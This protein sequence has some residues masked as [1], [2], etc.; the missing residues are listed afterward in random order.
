MN[1]HQPTITAVIIAKNEETMIA[2]CI[3]TVRWCQEILVID[4]GSTDTTAEL[5]KSLGA[6]IVSYKS[7]SFAD[8]RNQALKY[9]KTDWLFYLD[10]DERV[11]PRLQQEIS[12]HMETKS[13]A[14]LDMNRENVMYGKVFK[15]GGWQNDWVTRVFYRETFQGWQGEVHESA[16]FKGQ[17]I[18]LH[19]PLVHLT[20]RNTLDGLVKTMN[21]TPIE[22]ELMFKAGAESVKLSTLIRKSLMEVFRRAISR[23]GRLD[24][25]EGWIEALVQGMNRFLVYVQL[26]EKQQQP[27]LKEKYSQKELEI[28]NLWKAQKNRPSV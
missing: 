5:A 21:W 8:L 12:V 26:W 7:N 10:A 17:A 11:T 27:N 23:Q 22:A 2:N 18:Q 3:E 25:I 13:S 14:A 19:T 24:G 6:R 20:H 15:H 4:N 9:V 28:A 16:H 1:T